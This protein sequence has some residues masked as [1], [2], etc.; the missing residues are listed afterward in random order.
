MM[1]KI[2]LN[3]WS[4]NFIEDYSKLF[5]EFGVSPFGDLL[6]EVPNPHLYMRR[7]IIFGHRD[8][9]PI[10]DAMHSNQPF[11][12][13]SGFM[14]S[15]PVHLGHK[16]VMDEI[17]WHQRMGADAFFGIADMEAHAV[18]GIPWKECTE[19]GI[20]EYVLSVIALGFEPNGRIYFQ[21]KDTF[22][23]DL[24]FELGVEA[25]LSEM[26]A[27]YGFSGETHI[28]HMVSAL[29]QSADILHPQL[30]A[31]G[32]P[33]PVVIPVGFDQD[34]HIRL[35]RDIASRM[36]M[37]KVEQRE[38]Y[39]SVRA[40]HPNKEAMY[41]IADSLEGDVKIYAEHVDIYDNKDVR[42]IESVVRAVEIEHGGYGLILPSSIYHRFMS[43]LTGGKMSSSSPDSIIALTESPDVAA[44]KVKKAKT[45]GRVTLT[46]QRKLGG[47]PQKCTVYEL[48][49]FHLIEDDAHMAEIFTECKEGKRTC[50][51]C[52]SLAAELMIKF[53]REHQEGRERAKERLDEYGLKLEG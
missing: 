27:I 53:L 24:A 20:N 49:L 28:S 10:L 17:I 2:K 36:R 30:K 44:E 8:Y 4:T 22:V 33:K 46:D 7:Q 5:D 50:G 19:R 34:P 45:G 9:Q 52:K 3:P 41:E 37:F 18:R 11:G 32:G 26:S 21:S 23:K 35:T 47:E 51:S 12:V 38:D 48:L 6:A 13:M 43:G 16:M 29:V 42:K 15:G 1:R 25:N 31:Y 39:I 14:P 40:K